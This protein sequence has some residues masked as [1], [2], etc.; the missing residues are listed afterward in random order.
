MKY[1][2]SKNIRA[3]F[4]Y[5]IV[6]IASFVF[7]FVRTLADVSDDADQTIPAVFADIYNLLFPLAIIYGALEIIV[8]GYKI[9]KSEG[10]PKALTD[11]KQHLTDTVTGIIFLILALIILRVIVKSF[12]G[13]DL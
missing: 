11:A 8:A 5:T 9:M 4:V 10:E 3:L 12:L 1:S 13:Q 2:Y 6:G 7:P